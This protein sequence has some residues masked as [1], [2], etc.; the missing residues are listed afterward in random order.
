VLAYMFAT[1]VGLSILCFVI[2]II[3]TFAG[4]NSASF[5]EGLWPIVAVVPLVGLPLGFV[6]MIVLIVLSL[7]RRSREAAAASGPPRTR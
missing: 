1:M 4:M 6:V 7:R 5:A 2:I 3:A